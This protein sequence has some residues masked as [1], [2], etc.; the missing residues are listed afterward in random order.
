MLAEPALR[1]YAGPVARRHIEQHGLQPDAVGIVPG[2]AGGPKGLVLG[3]LD[4]FLF[5]EW[6]PRSTQPVDLVG[7]SVGALRMAAMCLDRPAE[8]LERLERD[9]LAVQYDVPPGRKTPTA[10][11]MSQRLAE[12][13]QAFYG[14]RVAEV[15]GH[16]RYRLHVVTSRGRHVLRRE[17]PVAT[18][19][20]LLGAVA[21][22]AAHRRALGAW[23]ERVVFS[24]PGAPLPFDAGAFPTRQVALRPD[25][26]LDALLAS[27]SP[28]FVLQAVHDIAGAPRG[29]YWDGGIIDYHLHLPYQPAD[30]RLVL[31]PH[32][33]R[34]VVPGW[35]DKGMRWRHAATSALDRMLVLAPD[36]AWMR[37]ALPLGK[38][39]DRRDFRRY[40][41]DNA[42]RIA[43]W[44][45]A[46]RQAQQLA[47]E[48]QD[49]LQ[50][51]DP[52]RLEAL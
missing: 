42:G 2:A 17:H 15:L 48:F 50:A 45:Q 35:L 11:H 29:A 44:S 24:T 40:G 32:F 7:S 49:W 12:D 46:V 27:C 36:P 28:P 25:N 1:L 10:A 13:L 18:P 8:A 51:P 39:P 6:L 9:Y 30:D 31:Y 3:P 52:K 16:R 21:S 43:A 33:Q 22:N 34:A 38:L 37:R 47:D 4:R 41:T 20:G 5:G 19:L 26:L 14:A 23:F